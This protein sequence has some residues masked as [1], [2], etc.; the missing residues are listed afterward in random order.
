MFTIAQVNAG[1]NNKR[2]FNFYYKYPFIEHVPNF[3]EFECGA[4]D[5]SFGKLLLGKQILQKEQP[6]ELVQSFV[7]FQ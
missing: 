1:T 4:P 3:V 7:E 6:Q 2:V 5:D